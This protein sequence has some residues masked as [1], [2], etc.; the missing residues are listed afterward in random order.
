MNEPLMESFNWLTPELKIVDS[1]KNS[2]KIRGIALRSNTISK[3]GRKYVDEE[4]QKAARTWIGKPFTVNHAPPTK[5]DAE[6]QRVPFDPSKII[7]NI[8]WMEHDDDGKLE[9]VAVV[10][11][12]PYV[13]MVRMYGRNPKESSIRGVSV[14]AN[15]LH[16]LCPECLKRGVE[17]RFYDEPSF[18]K[19]MSEEHFIKTDPTSEPHGIIGQAL[20]LVLAPEEP[21]VAGTTI[22]LMETEQHGLSRL[23]ETVIKVETENEE[24]GRKMEE[25][26]RGKAALSEEIRIGIG[27]GMLK[28]TVPIVEAVTPTQTV[29]NVP[30]TILDD[31]T[32]VGIKPKESLTKENLKIA[33]PCSPE[34]KACVDDLIAQGRP[35]DS[36]WAICRSKI[37]E[38]K[39]GNILPIKKLELAEQKTPTFEELRKEFTEETSALQIKVTRLA[40]ENN[41]LIME[42]INGISEDQKILNENIRIVHGDLL[43]KIGTIP[44]DDK[45]WQVQIQEVKTQ[46][47]STQ[48]ELTQKIAETNQKIEALPKDDLTWKEA[49]SK[50]P[51]DDVSWRETILNLPKDDLGWKELKIPDLAPLDKKVA[52]IKMP[53]LEPLLKD[54]ATLKDTK[55]I[56]E[57][58]RKIEETVGTQN[59]K[60]KEIQVL[61]DTITQNKKDFES[62]LSVADKNIAEVGKSVDEWRRK[63]GE[64]EAKLKEQEDRK[65]KETESTKIRLDNVEDKIGKGDFKG[66]HTLEKPGASQHPVNP[67]S[68]AK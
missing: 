47:D 22:E 12:Q 30:I 11:K 41:Q 29:Q 7:G 51:P 50:L 40:N 17:K 46:L 49:I 5:V 1:G 18:H 9:Y 39:L 23:L 42:I 2:V 20:S 63:A 61:R 62:I 25:K 37:G 55:T 35:E 4:L 64:F 56:D 26:L 15:F 28:P 66:K 31:T 44:E 54:I 14:E 3:N 6:R 32:K 38:T 24:E 53:D 67:V 59:E 52:E 58:F 13:D 33:E 68:G 8:E 27:K 10:N 34:L 65:L 57:R 43:G 21:G 16:N 60:L 45:G 48:G 36:A 19:H